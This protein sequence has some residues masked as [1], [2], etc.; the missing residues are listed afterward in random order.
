MPAAIILG[1][2]ASILTVK[3]FINHSSPATGLT[4]LSIGFVFLAIGIARK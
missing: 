1:L 3:A 4:F 2:A